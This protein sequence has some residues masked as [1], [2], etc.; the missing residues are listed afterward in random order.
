MC[1]ERDNVSTVGFWITGNSIGLCL[2]YLTGEDIPCSG[3]LSCSI[4]TSSEVCSISSGIYIRE[5]DS[6]SSSGFLDRCFGIGSN[7]SDFIS[8]NIDNSC[9]VVYGRSCCCVGLIDEICE[10]L[11]ES[12]RES[13]GESFGNGISIAE[14]ISIYECIEIGVDTGC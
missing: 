10:G 9:C 3:T 6:R 2:D 1:E 8:S 13:L 14:C 5:I 4:G 7:D 12:I 11:C